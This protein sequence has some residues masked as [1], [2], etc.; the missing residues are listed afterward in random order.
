MESFIKWGLAVVF[1][2]LVVTSVHYYNRYG[3]SKKNFQKLESVIDSLNLR[4]KTDSMLVASLNV[5]NEKCSASAIETIKYYDNRL[6]GIYNS[7]DKN[8]QIIQELERRKNQV[9][10]GDMSNKEMVDYINKNY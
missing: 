3:K 9:V 4:V 8:R 5:V 1:V 10:T 2:S 7:L 6:K